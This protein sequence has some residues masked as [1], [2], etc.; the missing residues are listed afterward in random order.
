MDPAEAVQTLLDLLAQA[1][2][3]IHFDTFLMS[4]SDQPGDELRLL[5]VAVDRGPPCDD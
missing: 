3:P 1:L 5:K 4:P 2:V